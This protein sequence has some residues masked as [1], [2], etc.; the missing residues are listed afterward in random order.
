MKQTFYSNGKL[1]ISGEYLVLDGAKALALPT[2]F[3]QNLIV[4]KGKNKEIVWK[5][6]DKDNSI[7]FNE[8]LLFSE[9]IEKK[10]FES[11][12]EK[13]TLIA[14]LHEAFLL[15][16]TYINLSEGY[17]VT[18]QLTFPKFWGLGTSST[19][20]NN[21][22]Q[23]IKID[24]FTLLKNSFGGSGYDI[25]CAQN[26]TPILY[27]L[28]NGKP[29]V[30]S[31]VFNPSF[32]NQLYFVYLN[33]KQSSKNAIASYYKKQNDIVPFITKINTIT[34][35]ILHS[36]EIES[37]ISEIE[38]HEII[39]S[40]ILETKTVKETLFS[41][42]SGTIKSLGAWGGDFVMA[43]SKENPSAYFKEKGFETILTYEEM[44]L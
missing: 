29:I 28:V 43:V 40:E 30:A 16:P 25:A 5:S 12:T 6:F 15:N 20:I 38:N 17:N 31:V 7:W 9:I 26:N 8:T 11:L 22:A 3:G 24:A 21:I 36:K 37:F 19:L 44:I 35:T 18:T 42:F 10:T 4:E 1:L 13:N 27:Q 34:N 32:T 39:L 14:I 33:K 2:K 23:W 41:D